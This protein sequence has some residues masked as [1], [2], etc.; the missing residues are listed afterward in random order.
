MLAQTANITLSAVDA[1][2]NVMDFEM[3]VRVNPGPPELS[4]PIS[5]QRLVLGRLQRFT[6]P[7]DTFQVNSPVDSLALR[8]SLVQRQVT[9]PSSL[10]AMPRH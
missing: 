2:G 7:A 1:L 6:L 4:R 8:A 10:Y 3:L 9:A 5:D